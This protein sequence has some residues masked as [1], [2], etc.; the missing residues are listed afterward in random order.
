[1]HSRLGITWIV[2]LCVSLLDSLSEARLSAL[3][4]ALL[5]TLVGNRLLR[6]GRLISTGILISV[7]LTCRGLISGIGCRLDRSAVLR[8]KIPLLAR[9]IVLRSCLIFIT[10]SGVFPLGGCALEPISGNPLRVVTVLI[11]S[12]PFPPVRDVSPPCCPRLN[13][14]VQYKILSFLAVLVNLFLV[15]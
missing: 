6:S 9:R 13:T 3:A 11:H 7:A 14:A 4:V 15:I 5:T 8:Q 10:L 12:I 1:M 2:P